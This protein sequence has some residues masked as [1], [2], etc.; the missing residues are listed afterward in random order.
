MDN[1][2]NAMI[3]V[4]ETD[5][6]ITSNGCANQYVQTITYQADDGCGNL[7]IPYVVTLTVNNTVAPTWE[8][9]PGSLNAEFVCSEDVVVPS[10]PVATD[11]CN[12]VD[13]IVSILSDTTAAGVCGNTFVRT[14]TYQ[15]MDDCGNLSETFTAT[16][17][18]TARKPLLG[19][20]PP[21]PWT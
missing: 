11:D 7:S 21:A 18:T 4:T 20:L 10:L 2:S 6:I 16:L 13:V 5:N 12:D 15:A 14:I 1:C 3:T 9:I 19:I 17:T 8:T